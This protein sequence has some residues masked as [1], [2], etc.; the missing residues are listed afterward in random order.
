MNPQK[1]LHLYVEEQKKKPNINHTYF[2]TE[3]LDGWYTY[4]DVVGTEIVSFK[5]RTHRVIPAL[6]PHHAEARSLLR[7]TLPMFQNFGVYSCRVLCE[8]VIPDM[9]FH[10]ANGLLNRT[11]NFA[12]LTPV[13]HI[14][15]VVPFGIDGACSGWNGEKRQRLVMTLDKVIQTMHYDSFRT[16]PVRTISS[17]KDDWLAEFHKVVDAGGEG[18]VLKRVDADYAPGARNSSLMKIKLEESFDLLCEGVVDTVGEKGNPNKNL[19]LVDAAGT[20]V[21]VR[22]GA[23]KDLETIAETS[24]VGHVIEIKCMTK[25]AS[26]GYREP[27]F[28]AFR[29]DKSPTDID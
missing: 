7:N 14:H 29:W 20:K 23:D 4:L 27:R 1:A 8:T 16:V 15:D 9:D 13:F 21:E 28:K 10:T 5:S 3:K 18:V 26:G 19:R 11:A 6:L 17:K 2:V 22:L 25:L 24:P 12:E